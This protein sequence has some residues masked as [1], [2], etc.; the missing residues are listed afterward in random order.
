MVKLL[1]LKGMMGASCLAPDGSLVAGQDAEDLDQV[2]AGQR[3]VR[4]HFAEQVDY[5]SYSLVLC[6]VEIF[7]NRIRADKKRPSYKSARSEEALL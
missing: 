6:I 2:F 3:T 1:K 4:Y 7:S 5:S